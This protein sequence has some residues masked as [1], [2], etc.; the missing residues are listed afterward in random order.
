MIRTDVCSWPLVEVTLMG[1]STNAELEGELAAFAETC[2][3]GGIWAMVIDLRR[4]RMNPFLPGQI[5]RLDDWLW[6][7]RHELLRDCAGA[8]VVV[9]EAVFGVAEELVRGLTETLGGAITCRLSTDLQRGRAWVLD[10]LEARGRTVIL[11]KSTSHSSV[12]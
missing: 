5:R 1:E 7:Q 4:A 12:V 2:L 11:A 6:A 10:R 8:A 9:D 3:S